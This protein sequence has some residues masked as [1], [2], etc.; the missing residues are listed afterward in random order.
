MER[1]QGSGEMQD[2]EDDEGYNDDSDENIDMLAPARQVDPKTIT[3]REE[4]FE[5]QATRRLM[6]L[7][8]AAQLQL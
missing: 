4:E 5:M 7:P 6:E 3:E 8:A 2:D 1:I